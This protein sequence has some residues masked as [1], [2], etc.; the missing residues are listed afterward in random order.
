MLTQITEKDLHEHLRA[1]MEQRGITRDEPERALREGWD[2]VDAKPGT[3]GKVLVFPFQEIW[4]GKSY[5]EK[6]VF[7]Y[8]KL[9]HGKIMLLT[10]KARYGQNFPQGEC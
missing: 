2:A 7:V 8:Y 9:L 3:V 4:E 5:V 1:R 10:V 6:E